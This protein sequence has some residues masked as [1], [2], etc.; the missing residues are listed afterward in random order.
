MSTAVEAS[1]RRTVLEVEDVRTRFHTRDGT[2][3][4]VN[5]ISFDLREG[6]LLGVVG[7]SGSGR[8]TAAMRPAHDSL[9]GRLVKPGRT[10]AG[11][12]EPS[13]W[14][15]HGSNTLPAP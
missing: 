3:H 6:E 5:G 13:L 8:Q 4:A 12:H 10:A 1:P 2:V 15:L 14:C 9:R 11:S 7:E